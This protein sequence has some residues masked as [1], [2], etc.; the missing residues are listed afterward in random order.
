MRESIKCSTCL[1]FWVSLI[2]LNTY[3][4]FSQ[5]EEWYGWTHGTHFYYGGTFDDCSFQVPKQ[6]YSYR[7]TGF[8]YCTGVNGLGI[9]VNETESIYISPIGDRLIGTQYG[10][11]ELN[12]DGNNWTTY[13][14]KTILNEGPNE[15][16]ESIFKD[17]EGEIWIG[18]EVG[19]IK[20]LKQDG[21]WI[22]HE[23]KIPNTNFLGTA[24]AIKEDYKNDIIACGSFGLA[25]FDRENETWSFYS[26]LGNGPYTDFTFDS[27]GDIWLAHQFDGL[28]HF[29]AF[30]SVVKYTTQNSNISS[31]F[32]TAVYA[33][34]E[35]HNNE[36][37]YF[38]SAD[39][40][41]GSYHVNQSTFTTWQSDGSTWFSN[42]VN[43]LDYD[44]KNKILW[45]ATNVGVVRF[46]NDL[47]K[48]YRPFDNNHHSLI[49]T[50]IEVDT[51]NNTVWSLGA[52]GGPGVYSS[53][54]DAWFRFTDDWGL[55][56]NKFIRTAVDP[57]DNVWVV[58]RNNPGYIGQIF[59]DNTLV[60]ASFDYDLQ[61]LKY[62]TNDIAFAGNLGFIAT[63][64]GFWTFNYQA[65][66]NFIHRE[67]DGTTSI[68]VV[69]V[70]EV[71][72]E[73]NVWL[74]T[75][76]DGLIKYKNGLYTFYTSLLDGLISNNINHVAFDAEGNIWVAS[77]DN[78]VAKYSSNFDLIKHFTTSNSLL[79]NNQVN[80]VAY[81]LKNDRLL[82]ATESG[83]FLY[84]SEET[85][86][87]LPDMTASVLG[88]RFNTVQT[89][90]EGIIYAGTTAGFSK[91]DDNLNEWVQVFDKTNSAMDD[92]NVKDLVINR[93]GDKW[94]VGFSSTAGGL[95]QFKDGGASGAFND[96]ISSSN[97][98]QISTKV[99][100]I[101]PNPAHQKAFL[102]LSSLN[103]KSANVV[104]CNA[105]GK[106]VRSWENIA[107]NS[108][109]IDRKNLPSGVYIIRAKEENNTVI[110][111]L[112]FE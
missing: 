56:S 27:E 87:V 5:E 34:F 43:D 17:S 41:F 55:N 2:L 106:T 71:D 112:I 77:Q 89:D 93:K 36:K 102:D 74:C 39:N 63:D 76:T 9:P 70:V 42:I 97:S 29:D 12:A 11:A 13:N 103:G 47:F 94:M 37:I 40:G 68:G 51:L 16:V 108:L 66:N 25:E 52:F 104:M 1:L 57:S 50:D 101:F 18:H 88:K 107:Q 53:N 19:G 48:T 4:T 30:S 75:K 45:L 82:A 69:N 86:A 10:F 92:N 28:V 62:I 14:G 80:E 67:G 8:G 85:Q 44:P 59:K 3:N 81:D 65:N 90:S 23:I 78:G 98:T 99:L 31:N 72:A 26:Q 96:V 83:L 54:N 6:D 109:E 111:R 110:A 32:L 24:F 49:N 64:L 61:G 35:D 22:V 100:N 60:N 20:Q 7:E 15:V 105:L 84:T 46:A 91:Y 58:G 73:D 79:P 33:E 21:T 38:S 95:F